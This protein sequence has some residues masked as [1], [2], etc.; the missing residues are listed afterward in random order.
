MLTNAIPRVEKRWRPAR[1]ESGRPKRRLKNREEGEEKRKR[2]RAFSPSVQQSMSLQLN[3]IRSGTVAGSKSSRKR[4]CSLYIYR[5][6]PTTSA[7]TER[8]ILLFCARP[9]WPG[10]A[11]P[12]S[13]WFWQIS[14][15]R[16]NQSL[17][18]VAIPVSPLRSSLFP[19]DPTC[20]SASSPSSSLATVPSLYILPLPLSHPPIHPAGFDKVS[21]H[22]SQSRSTSRTHPL[23]WSTL[24]ACADIQRKASTLSDREEMKEK[25]NMKRETS[26][27]RR[28]R[29]TRLYSTSILDQKKS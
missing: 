16:P 28:D 9:R 2:V 13:T 10:P 15:D 24:S 26:F 18:P 17:P 14:S 19:P 8:W 20:H 22:Q 25:Y 11:L 7:R 5:R 21:A 29:D 4:P 6:R 12:A 1:E 23:R 3:S 27:F